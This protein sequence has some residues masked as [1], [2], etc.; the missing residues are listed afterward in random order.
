VST[1]RPSE[2]GFYKDVEALVREAHA[3]ATTGPVVY[4]GRS[5]GGAAAGFATRV[6]RPDRVIVESGF[7]D[8]QTLLA[9]TPVLSLFRFF[10]SYRFQTAAWLRGYDG[11]V[12]VM[13]GDRDSVIPYEQ[14]ERLFERL[15]GPRHFFRVAGG[16]HNDLLPP[17]EGRYWATVD[18]FIRDGVVAD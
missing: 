18:A 10:A 4:W 2:R 6:H 9:A 15:L 13:H 11:P 14:G 17:D 1:G 5:L 8:V 16:D 3:R 7:S 12:L